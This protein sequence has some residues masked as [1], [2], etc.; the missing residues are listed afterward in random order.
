MTGLD[1]FNDHIIEICCIITDGNLRVV[2]QEGYESVIH[3]DKLT[4]DSMND[5]CIEH[6]GD[7]SWIFFLFQSTTMALNKLNL[8]TIAFLKSG[9]TQK[10]LDSSKTLAQ[11]EQELLEYVSKYTNQRS[12]VL[13]GNSVHMDRA[14][15]MRE[16]P[17]VLEHLHYRIIDVSTL[18]E[19]GKRHN[20][21]LIS[22]LPKKKEAHTARSDILESI[23]QLKWYQDN[24]LVQPS[25]K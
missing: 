4:M 2:D 12:A 8:L 13:A 3:Y 23:A 9:L 15:M 20:S 14:F 25:N 10:V 22:K 19:I 7:V 5:W 24:Y 6:H 16:M 18:T 11:V 1:V 17:K 21:E